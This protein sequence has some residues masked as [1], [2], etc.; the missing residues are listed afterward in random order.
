MRHVPLASA[1]GTTATLKFVAGV[2]VVDQVIPT[3]ASDGWLVVK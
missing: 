2:V 1:F 3:T